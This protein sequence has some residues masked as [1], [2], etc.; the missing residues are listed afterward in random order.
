MSPS[1]DP[2]PQLRLVELLREVFS[3]EDLRRFVRLGPEGSQIAAHLPEHASVY[4]LAT[5]LVGLLTRRGE[6]DAA[7]FARLVR[8]RPRREREIAAVRRAVLQATTGAGAPRARPGPMFVLAM[9]I[10]LAA[11]ALAAEY[12]LRGVRA[13]VVAAEPESEPRAQTVPAS[14]LEAPIV[15]VAEPTDAA[16][17]EA[18]VAHSTRMQPRTLTRAALLELFRPLGPELLTCERAYA[19]NSGPIPPGKYQ[20]GFS[21]DG[22][23]RL[24]IGRPSEDMMSKWDCFRDVLTSASRTAGGAWRA[25]SPVVTVDLEE[26]VNKSVR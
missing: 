12:G 7:F 26:I 9:C 5:Q 1:S 16:P 11:A 17:V 6:L 13:P 25:R 20:I 2:S 24:Q 14:E 19:T 22:R 21:T 23:G 15:R 10:S 8:E 3:G 4:E 18:Q